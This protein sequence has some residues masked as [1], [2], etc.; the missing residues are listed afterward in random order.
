MSNFP[1]VNRDLLIIFIPTIAPTFFLR[2]LIQWKITAAKINVILQAW[3]KPLQS[4]ARL[5][6][7]QID[8]HRK[9]SLKSVIRRNNRYSVWN[10]C[11][12]LFCF[13]SWKTPMRYNVKAPKS[14]LDSNSWL[15]SIWKWEYFL[16][17]S[18]LDI[19]TSLLTAAA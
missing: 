9:A 11:S 1:T 12:A 19:P 6:H 13:G 7:F 10:L 18:R 17:V 14:M 5:V 2:K 15:G 3:I 8:T 4:F 16:R